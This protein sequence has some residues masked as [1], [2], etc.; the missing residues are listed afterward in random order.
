M[1]WPAKFFFCWLLVAGWAWAEESAFAPLD[2]ARHDLQALQAGKDGLL[3][4]DST[5]HLTIN[6]PIAM[7]VPNG[8]GLNAVVLPAQKPKDDKSHWLIDAMDAQKKPSDRLLSDEKPADKDQ[9]SPDSAQKNAD[10]PDETGLTQKT[11]AVSNPLT[12][13]LE[14]WMTPQDHALLVHPSSES[15][16]GDIASS[17]QPEN[18]HDDIAANV[19]PLASPAPTELFNI[20]GSPAATG[21][22]PNL[23]LSSGPDLSFD[24][25]SSPSGATTVAPFEPAGPPQ[26]PSPMVAP[27]APPP[28][29]PPPFAPT[30]DNDKYFPQL[31]NRF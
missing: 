5:V 12:P 28:A 16:G 13:Y 20:P 15:A 17:I 1:C 22:K 30:D 2:A 7:P 6:A 26:P 18:L 27:A 19:A 14:Q 25:L 4:D 24:A 10:R 29:V 3:G 23:Y 21:T 31:K 8:P 11:P 9:S